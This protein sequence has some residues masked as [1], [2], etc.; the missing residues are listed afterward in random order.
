M[1]RKTLDAL[2]TEP[3]RASS[4]GFTLVETVMALAVGAIMLSALY[5]AFAF[6]YRTIGVTREDLRATEIMLQRLERVRLC[7]FSQITDTSINPPT[8]TEYADP[9]D[10]ASGGGGVPYTV[11]FN[12]SVPTVGTLPEAYRTNMLLVTVGA[13]WSRGNM[14]H[15]RTMQTYVAQKGIES[16]VAT[17]G[18]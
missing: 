17:G 10:Q 6:G 15:S 3:R 2:S 7:T 1:R 18:R 8:T 13:S 5:N 12:T 11:T 4:A 16:Y 9:T 14:P